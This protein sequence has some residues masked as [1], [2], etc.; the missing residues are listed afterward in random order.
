MFGNI[1]FHNDGLSPGVAVAPP[2]ASVT[3]VPTMA[4][5]KIGVSDVGTV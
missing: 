4:M 5:T 2:P 1:G 3:G